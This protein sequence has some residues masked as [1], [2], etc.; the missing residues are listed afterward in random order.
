MQEQVYKSPINDVCE[1]KLRLIEAWSAMPQRV[2]D[3]AVDEWR[4]RLR[5]CVS[6]GGRHFEH[7]L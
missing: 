3:K 1:L 2:V 5:L 7:K 4:K 6:A